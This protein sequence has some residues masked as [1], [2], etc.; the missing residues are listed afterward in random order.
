[1]ILELKKEEYEAEEFGVWFALPLCIG[2]HS[3]LYW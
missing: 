2:S 3:S 1:M